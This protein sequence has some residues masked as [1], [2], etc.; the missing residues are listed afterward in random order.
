[1]QFVQ[2]S[3]KIGFNGS[4]DCFLSEYR[5]KYKWLGSNGPFAGGGARATQGYSFAPLGLFHLPFG[6]TAC[7]VGCNLA[8]P[9]GWTGC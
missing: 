9:R 2:V 8:P 7:A 6:P 1:M 5:P 4:H 3:F